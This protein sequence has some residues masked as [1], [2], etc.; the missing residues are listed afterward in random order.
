MDR[1]TLAQTTVTGTIFSFFLFLTTSCYE[2]EAVSS[3]FMW[4]TRTDYDTSQHL[5]IAFGALQPIIGVIIDSLLMPFTTQFQFD[6]SARRLFQKWR[7]EGAGTQ[8][9]EY[10][11]LLG[12]LKEQLKSEKHS[13]D[14]FQERLKLPERQCISCRFID[15]LLLKPG[16]IEP[17]I[18]FV[19]AHYGAQETEGLRE[20][21]RRHMAHVYWAE[22]FLAAAIL[23]CLIGYF[24]PDFIL[25]VQPCPPK[26]PAKIDSLGLYVLAALAVWCLLMWILRATMR[27]REKDMVLLWV[28]DTILDKKKLTQQGLPKD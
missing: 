13:I 21:G 22:N 16:R 25:Y 11:D 18:D 5:I 17:D 24:F 15:R 6:E 9:N 4:I 3:F 8:V 27:K 7:R 20:W 2:P 14:W 19:V 1:I 26:E 12:S 28:L 10:D 23:G